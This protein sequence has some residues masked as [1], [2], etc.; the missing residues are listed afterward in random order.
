MREGCEMNNAFDPA[1]GQWYA[2]LDK[3]QQ[4]EV[5]AVD[6]DARTVEIQ[7]FDG[8]LEELDEVTWSELAIE[9]IEAPMDATGP[10][11]DVE[12]DD[13]G[14]TADEME[15]RDWQ[16]P[17]DELHEEVRHTEHWEEEEEESTDE[18]AEG[19]LEQEPWEEAARDES[20]EGRG[21]EEG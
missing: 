10:A 5:V 20:D 6:A 8:G 15:E 11:D 18:W 9:P 21:G 17:L 14:Y 2:H 19:H 7:Y 16:E 3:G 13:L 12:R 1:V 4:F